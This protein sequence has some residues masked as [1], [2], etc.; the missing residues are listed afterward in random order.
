MWHQSGSFCVIQ[1]RLV[2]KIRLHPCHLDHSRIKLT[3]ASQAVC[4]LLCH[5]MIKQNIKSLFQSQARGLITDHLEDS[6]R[7][8]I[9]RI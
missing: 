9:C 7:Y 6:I 3:L 5:M 2:I 8:Y 4:Q 1:C